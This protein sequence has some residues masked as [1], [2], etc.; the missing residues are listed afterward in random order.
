MDKYK[1]YLLKEDNNIMYIGI[2]KN[3]PKKRLSGHIKDAKVNRRNPLKCE[4]IRYMIDNNKEIIIDVIYEYDNKQDAINKEIELISLYGLDNLLNLTTGGE[5]FEFDESVIKRLSDDRVGKYV[6]D[7]NP[8]FGKK[9]EDLRNFNLSRDKEFYKN[10]GI[11]NG[12]KFKEL[13]NT[14]EY[15]QIHRLNQKTRKMIAQYD[16]DGN[17]IKIWDSMSQIE[18]EGKSQKFYRKSIR[19]CLNGKYKQAHGFIWRYYSEGEV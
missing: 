13:Y 18:S 12:E 11:K 6:G 14:K 1:V 3:T 2:T 19:F 10:L 16:F 4:W 7:K 17:L 9:R 15:K 5:Y 8:M